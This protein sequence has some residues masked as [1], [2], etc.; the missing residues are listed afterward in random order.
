MIL[1]SFSLHILNGHLNLVILSL[2]ELYALLAISLLAQLCGSYLLLYAVDNLTFIECKERVEA[3]NLDQM[4]RM[5]ALCRQN[6]ILR[7]LR[8]CLNFV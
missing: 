6:L 1:A 8:H 2:H 4:Y 3:V 7:L 5:L